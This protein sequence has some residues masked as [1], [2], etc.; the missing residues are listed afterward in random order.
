M[1][2][3]MG[4][5]GPSRFVVASFCENVC[6]DGCGIEIPAI[7][8]PGFV[9]PQSCVMFLYL[10]LDVSSHKEVNLICKSLYFRYK[11]NRVCC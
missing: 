1:P 2:W 11:S 4:V 5:L 3:S 9:I 8:S 7:Q 10:T 6:T